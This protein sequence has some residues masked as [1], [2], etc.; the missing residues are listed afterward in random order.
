MA[1]RLVEKYH[2]PTILISLGEDGMAKGSC[3]SI[4]ALNLYEAIAAESDILTQFGGHH[5]AAGLTL[6]ADKVAEFRE[7]FRVYVAS[8]L[9]PEDYLP[10]LTVDCVVSGTGEITEQD[11]QQ[12]ALL[13]P[14]GCEN[15]PPVFAF[16]KAVLH[17]ERTMGKER[18]HLQ[19][20]LDKGDF[21]YRCVMWNN[22]ELLPFL[23]DGVVADVA[24]QPKL[25]V[26]NNERSVQLHA[27]SV[28]QPLT[29]GDWRRSGEDKWELLRA[30]ARVQ[31]RLTV[32]VSSGDAS[33]LSQKLVHQEKAL[34][35]YLDVKNYASCL[36]Q[37]DERLAQLV[38]IPLQPTVV[39]F[40]L[41][42][43]PLKDILAYLK[44]HEAKQ[45]ILLYNNEDWQRSLLQ[46]AFTHPDREAMAMAYKLVM[47]VLQSQTKVECAQLLAEN[48]T[49]IS[50]NA[51]KIMEQLGFISYNNGIIK[52]GVIK[53][54]S[55][56]DAP[57]YVTLQ[58]ERAQLERIYQENIKLS[59]HDL[60]RG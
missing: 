37:S 22:A 8:H 27:M 41:P 43:V 26:W 7:R 14:C 40:D 58:Q 18:N 11:L 31:D 39:L 60:L 5:Q 29:L 19:F 16:H 4:P 38:Q 25:N 55:L 59:Q 28:R 53:R 15:M 21:S 46:L 17:N 12:L 34:F 33:M 48:S 32:F 36:A 52:K 20:T 30:L 49:Q 13:E 51:V 54:C 3:R 23:C 56:E 45:I 9:Q 57:L 6:P 2:L 47:R 24:F 35:A 1:S 50:E 42:Q 44:K 10:H